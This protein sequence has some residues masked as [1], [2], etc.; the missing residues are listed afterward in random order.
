MRHYG[1]SL[2]KQG[3]DIFHW[4]NAR[5]HWLHLEEQ[6]LD[7]LKREINH[8]TM[9]LLA[10][11]Q[12][13]ACLDLLRL[14]LPTTPRNVFIPDPG[15]TSFSNGTL[16]LSK[17]ERTATFR[18]HQKEDFILYKIPLEFRD[19]DD[20]RNPEFETMVD[21]VFGTDAEGAA[22]RATLAQVYGGALVPCFPRLVLLLG[23]PGTGKS[24]IITPLE[25]ILGN[26]NISRVDPTRFRQD[27]GLSIMVGKLL[28]VVKDINLDTRLCT[29]DLKNVEDGG[30]VTVRRIYRDPIDARIPALHLYGANELP[31]SLETNRAF[32]RRW[33]ILV[34]DQF[35]PSGFYDRNFAENVV[36]RDPQGVMN[37]AVSG[38][39]DLLA[40]GGHYLNPASGV[41]QMDEWE[42]SSDPVAQF[43]ADLEA[44]EVQ[45]AG[46]YKT[47]DGESYL[48]RTELFQV[49]DEWRETGGMR[50]LDLPRHEFYARLRSRGV[51]DKIV[52]GVRYFAGITR[53][54]GEKF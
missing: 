47:H 2:C 11:R 27:Y 37:F 20:A 52:D 10:P 49:F 53:N 30:T 22:K 54:P 41:Q 5:G 17:E 18:G 8:T 45:I 13:D 6:H 28:N 34:C 4:K 29:A 14:Y 51:R 43:L 1:D 24:S 19:R 16:A 25:V 32:R 12:I 35:Q 3:E 42:L 46:G 21:R 26:E 7:R 33:S 40:R 23:K 31:R 44:G 36:R 39:Q 9:N 48:K 15:L 50:R 38:L